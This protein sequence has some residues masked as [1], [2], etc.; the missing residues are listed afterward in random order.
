MK[1]KRIIMIVAIIVVY[2]LVFKAW[3]LL[4]YTDTKGLVNFITESIKGY[5]NPETIKIETRAVNNYIEFDKLKIENIF[6]GYE[7]LEKKDDTLK[8][9]V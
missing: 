9:I 4:I 8:Y 7:Q 5:K 2:F 3:N 1:V 6:K